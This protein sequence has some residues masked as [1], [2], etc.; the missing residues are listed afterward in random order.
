MRQKHLQEA[1]QTVENWRAELRQAQEK[2]EA[3]DV[4]LFPLR[5]Y[6]PSTLVLTFV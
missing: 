3:G 5:F 2:K 1:H 4:R 6:A